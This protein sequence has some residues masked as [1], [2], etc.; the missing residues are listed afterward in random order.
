MA[1]S[2]VSGSVDVN[3]KRLAGM[4]IKRRGLT[5]NEVIK[6]VWNHIASTGEIPC[7]DAE[8]K[9]PAQRSQAFS[10]LLELRSG[11]PAGTPLDSMDEDGMRK[12]L[13]DRDE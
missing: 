12:E 9:A 2:T 1:T 7:I 4:Y 6:S 8:K 3:V 5:A 13:R 10:Q 11:V